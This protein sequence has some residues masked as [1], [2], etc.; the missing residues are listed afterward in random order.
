MTATRQFHGWNIDDG[1]YGGIIEEPWKVD[2]LTPSQWRL[3]KQQV[4]Q[5]GASFPDPE[6]PGYTCVRHRLARRLNRTTVI[7]YAVYVKPRAIFD[8]RRR[9][10]RASTEPGTIIRPVVRHRA[11]ALPGIYETADD[12]TDR[13]RIV[14]TEI[15]TGTGGIPVLGQ[16]NLANSAHVGKVAQLEPQN[17]YVFLGGTGKFDGQNSL[18]IE[19]EFYTN[20]WVK[21]LPANTSPYNNTVVVPDLPPLHTWAADMGASPPTVSIVPPGGRW[22]EFNP[23]VLP[24]W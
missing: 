20:G 23:G 18:R 5:I 14:R 15:R 6:Y 7:G 3:W 9:F 11:P 17:Y 4:P 22:V 16:V 24:L 1:L 13:A 10:S 8:G 12:L 21:G 2:E 19:Y